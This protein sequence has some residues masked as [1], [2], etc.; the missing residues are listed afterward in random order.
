MGDVA[1]RLNDDWEL[2]EIDVEQTATVTATYRHAS[3][4]VVLWSADPGHGVQVWYPDGECEVWLDDDH[5]PLDSATEAVQ[6]CI[7]MVEH[8]PNRHMP[9]TPPAQRP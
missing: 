3:G 5:A 1:D 6:T 7:E 4:V 2:D 9:P 8:Q